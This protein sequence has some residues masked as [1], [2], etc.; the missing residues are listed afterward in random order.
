MRLL[1]QFSGIL[2]VQHAVEGVAGLRI[3]LQAKRDF[4]APEL[5]F[6]R[7]FCNGNLCQQFGGFGELVGLVICNRRR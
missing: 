4:S 3:I 5:L 2:T 7:A 6:G 1:K